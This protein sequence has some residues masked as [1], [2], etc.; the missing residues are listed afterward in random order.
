MPATCWPQIAALQGHTLHTVARHKAFTVQKVTHAQAEL[1]V[2]DGARVRT[3]YRKDLE[4]I[5]ER[6]VRQG[7]LTI[8]EIKTVYK[9]NSSL[10]AA[11]LAA[12]PG[13][14]ATPQPITLRYRR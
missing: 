4:P 7:V 13:V 8:A 3:L 1:V 6:L 2:H 5:Y 9:F 14:T 11:L 12:L 10:A